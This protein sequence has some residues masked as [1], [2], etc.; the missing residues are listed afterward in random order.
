[1]SSNPTLKVAPTTDPDTDSELEDLILKVRYFNRSVH[2]FLQYHPYARLRIPAPRLHERF[3]YF[4]SQCQNLQTHYGWTLASDHEQVAKVEEKL[5]TRDD[6]RKKKCE[7]DSLRMSGEAETVKG[8]LRT[9]ERVQGEL[10]RACQDFEQW[11][12]RQ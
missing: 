2:T 8:S 12:G 10:E 4:R 5:V 7:L 3:Q 1:M 11:A 6:V 9:F